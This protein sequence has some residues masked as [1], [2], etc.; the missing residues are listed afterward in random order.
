LGKNSTPISPSRRLHI[1][2]ALKFTLIGSFA[3]KLL[4][5]FASRQ[6]IA[7]D[8][9][10]LVGG[11]SKRPSGY[12]GNIP[13]DVEAYSHRR[14]FRLELNEKR[15]TEIDSNVPIH[16]LEAHPTE[17]HIGLALPRYSNQTCLI[18]WKLGKETNLLKLPP[19]LFFYGHG[20]FSGDGKTVVASVINSAGTENFL[21]V[22]NAET[23][24]LESLI[25]FNFGSNHDILRLTSSS[26]AIA[27][28]GGS[29]RGPSQSQLVVF[30]LETSKFDVHSSPL[31]PAFDDES[32]LGSEHLLMI[33]PTKVLGCAGRTLHGLWKNTSV[34]EFD[35]ARK[36]SKFEVPPMSPAFLNNVLSLD[37]AAD[38]RIWI[39]LP[40]LKQVA[41]WNPKQ[42]ELDA[43]LN[44]DSPARS[45]AAVDSLGLV[46]L[47]ID[48]GFLSFDAVTMKESHQYKWPRTKTFGSYSAH[49]RLI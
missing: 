8:Q 49:T 21:A 16:V 43:I 47:G 36:E 13:Y 18:D 40:D 19:G 3:S 4:G 30:D 11:F 42:Q 9:L 44:F 38:G 12:N 46:V 27:G 6:S 26:F 14:A 33:S 48:G 7:G 31:F 20:V 29:M 17:R 24:L 35:L 1:E 39:S 41:V 2:Q 22:I 23:F 28:G 5:P 37:L 45:I 15:I 32:I 10:S 25:P 34:V